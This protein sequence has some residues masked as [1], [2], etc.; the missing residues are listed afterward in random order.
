MDGW[1]IFNE[2]EIEDI[3]NSPLEEAF[4]N[5]Q[6]LITNLANIKEDFIRDYPIKYLLHLP[7]VENYQFFLF[8]YEN[9]YGM[10]L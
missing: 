2:K 10:Q 1:N 4:G 6:V 7:D 8:K 3:S 9:N 5:G